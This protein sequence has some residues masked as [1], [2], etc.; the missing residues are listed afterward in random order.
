MAFPPFHA[1]CPWRTVSCGT[2]YCSA[3]IARPAHL[4]PRDRPLPRRLLPVHPRQC[5]WPPAR[6]LSLAAAWPSRQWQLSPCHVC[7]ASGKFRPSQ[8]NPCCRC[9][10]HVSIGCCCRQWGS[11]AIA[12]DRKHWGYR[13]VAASSAQPAPKANLGTG[14]PAR[15]GTTGQGVLKCATCRRGYVLPTGS[16]G[17]Q[18]NTCTESGV[19]CHVCN[20]LCWRL[21]GIV[22][23]LPHRHGSGACGSSPLLFH[24]FS[25][26]VPCP[27]IETEPRKA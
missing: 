2:S 17:R 24:A 8:Y 19:A 6:P 27:V 3:P 4:P 13:P 26:S 14:S 23:G 11:N 20:V 7:R 5:L 1:S 22:A 10:H 15:C 21:H 25:P 16:A 9:Q 18:P 12:D